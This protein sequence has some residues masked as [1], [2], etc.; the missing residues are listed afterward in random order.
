MPQALKCVAPAL[1]TA[2]PLKN[3][4]IKIRV[5]VRDTFVLDQNPSTNHCKRSAHE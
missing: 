4:E 5:F 2:S 1:S 3:V